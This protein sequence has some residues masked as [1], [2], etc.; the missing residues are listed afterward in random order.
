MGA[1]DFR[2]SFGDVQQLWA[3]EC[4]I[5]TYGQHGCTGNP[6]GL[7]GYR[8]PLQGNLQVCRATRAE[9]GS[10]LEDLHFPDYPGASGGTV[11]Q[12]LGEGC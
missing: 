6:C 8:L 3:T 1:R 4:G 7:C 9:T 10:Q 5:T 2:H 11:R 12:T